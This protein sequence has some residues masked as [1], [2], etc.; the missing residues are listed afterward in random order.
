MKSTTITP[1]TSIHPWIQ[2]LPD[3]LRILLAEELDAGNSVQFVAGTGPDPRTAVL[4][5]LA[6]PFRRQPAQVPRGITYLENEND[7]WASEY[8]TDDASSVLAAAPAA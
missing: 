4:I 8:R 3:P 6:E 2:A 7:W 1:T 5:V